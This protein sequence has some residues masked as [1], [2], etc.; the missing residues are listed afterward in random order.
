MLRINLRRAQMTTF[1]KKLP[2]TEIAM[3]ACGGAHHWARELTALGHE[4]RLI[5][6]QYV[7]PYVKRAKTI[8]MTPGPS[9]RRQRD[10]GCI[11]GR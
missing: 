5:R 3:E 1:F 7:K 10:R 4:I 6:P 11:S 8:A 9:A 2:Q